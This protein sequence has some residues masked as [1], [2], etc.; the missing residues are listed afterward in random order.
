M[1][2]EFWTGKPVSEE[3]KVLII[4]DYDSALDDAELFK[5]L[6]ET[7]ADNDGQP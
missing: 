4:A 5:V 3:V 7:L 6:L 1:I 2:T